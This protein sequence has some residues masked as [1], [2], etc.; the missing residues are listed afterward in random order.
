M[1]LA[2]TQTMTV[3]V[4]GTVSISQVGASFTTAAP[5]GASVTGQVVY[6]GQ[7]DVARTNIQI[8]VTSTALPAGAT[9]VAFTLYQGIIQSGAGTTSWTVPPG[10]TFRVLAI[11][12]GISCS[13][14]TTPVRATV[15]ILVSTTG[16]L[17]TFAATVGFLA[18]VQVSAGATTSGV[19]SN[20]V[21]GLA[22]DLPATS[23]LAMG[24]SA[25]TT[26]NFN[27]AVVAGYLFP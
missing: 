2:P 1:W 16:V 20:Q 18:A 8:V 5:V 15:A 4:S 11:Q 21:I 13:I 27:G 14:S 12:A 24:V 22:Q 6:L 19:V 23:F 3:A 10:K 25:A 26:C 9:T 17:P 7:M